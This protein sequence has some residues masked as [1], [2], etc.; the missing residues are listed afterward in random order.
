[1]WRREAIRTVRYMTQ[2]SDHTYKAPPTAVITG[3][4]RGLGLALARSLAADGWRLIINGR[5]PATLHV[6][7]AQL[8][9]LTHVKALPGDVSDPEHR[10][11]IADTAWNL[12]G[13]QAIVHNASLLGP[14]HRGGL[15]ALRGLSDYP[16][17]GLREVL[18]VN[19][20]A[21]VALT[22]LL[23]PLL[24]EQ[25]RVVAV[26]SDAAVEAYEGWGG[27]GAAKAALEQYFAV[28]AAERPDLRIY[29]VDPGEMRTQMYQ[30]AEPGED[31]SHLPLPDVSVPGIK[32]LLAGSLPS[33]RYQAR[34]VAHE[35][36]AA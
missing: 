2:A 10:E 25:A 20:L 19:A 12:G 6:A 9:E 1:M 17:A 35:E 14:T 30:E 18:E 32:A 15:P 4:S 23:L 36:V 22:Q 34:S 29:R 3:A 7:A 28:L 11:A 24:G 8:G 16:L 21:P 13:L 5:N 33:G 26:T 31:I 27:Y